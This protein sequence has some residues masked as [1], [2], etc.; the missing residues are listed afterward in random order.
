MSHTS[1]VPYAALIQLKT[2]SYFPNFT[3]SLLAVILFCKSS[4]K[5]PLPSDIA[6]RVAM[7][8]ALA[9]YQVGV[10]L[11]QDLRESSAT[12]EAQPADAT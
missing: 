12:T 3:S 11:Q 5:F 1:D 10:L 2:G 8:P 4:G 9:T 6:R 7:L